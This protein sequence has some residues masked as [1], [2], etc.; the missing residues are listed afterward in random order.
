L[1][2]ISRLTEQK[3]QDYLMELGKMGS[4]IDP[5]K[6][7][8]EI[9]DS[10]SPYKLGNIDT[11]RLY[12]REIQSIAVFFQENGFTETNM[13]ASFD[14][15][16][17]PTYLRSIRSSASFSSALN[18]QAGE[19]DLFYIT[20]HLPEGEN[21]EEKESKKKRLHREYKFLSAHEVIPGHHLLDHERRKQENLIR[22]QIESPF[23]YE[24]WA[25]YAETLLGDYAYIHD[26]LDKLVDHKR[27]L[28][29]AARCKIDVDLNTGILSR[30]E[31]M[32]ILTEM[33]FTPGEAEEQVIRIQLSPG[34]QMCYFLG[35]H[36][37][38]QLRKSFGIQLGIEYFHQLLLRGGQLPFHLVKKRLKAYI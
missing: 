13:K 18:T 29:R 1:P 17:T 2:D 24:G 6:S 21:G 19:K 10:Y 38:M 4:K 34:Y 5:G 32:K 11:M 12:E 35:N 27:R 8:L 9:Y 7:W 28:W 31:A 30:T 15:C 26:P 33:G 37:I 20:T 14:L 22:R 3:M 16:E 36:E 25:S 23:F